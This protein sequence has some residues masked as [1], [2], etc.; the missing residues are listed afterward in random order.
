MVSDPQDWALVAASLHGNASDC[1]LFCHASL[2]SRRHEHR[3]AWHLADN[4]DAPMESVGISHDSGENGSAASAPES[5]SDPA[6]GRSCLHA[7]WWASLWCSLVF[8]G[9]VL[10]P[11]LVSAA[12][13]NVPSADTMPT[14]LPDMLPVTMAKGATESVSGI[15]SFWVL[16][17]LLSAA[18]YI[19]LTHR[20]K[21][22]ADHDPDPWSEPEFLDSVLLL[23][24]EQGAQLRLQALASADETALPAKGQG[25]NSVCVHFDRS[26]I[27]LL[28]EKPQSDTRA[29]SAPVAHGYIP[30]PVLDS[31]LA[32]LFP[33]GQRV[34][35]DFCVKTG[36]ENRTF[37]FDTM[38]LRHDSPANA[39]SIMSVPDIDAFSGLP[40]GTSVLELARP[41]RV[42]RFQRR[43]FERIR[44][45]RA[46]I[47]ALGVW[48][49]QPGPT[50]PRDP[51]NLAEFPAPSLAMLPQCKENIRIDNIS[52]NGLALRVRATTLAETRAQGA[53]WR[54]CIVFLSL[55]ENGHHTC[56]LWLA[57]VR[58]HATVSASRPSSA[59]LG[60]EIAGW[61]E[62]CNAQSPINWKPVASCG[63]TPPLL[64]W[65]IRRLPTMRRYR[66]IN[67]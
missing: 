43:T 14:A 32:P 28:P 58:R 55:R 18:A 53:Q 23:A 7:P 13:T 22:L 12:D 1:V 47:A 59:V 11:S 35:V 50:L 65:I 62:T 30:L 64:R 61:A 27:I 67:L 52:A 46:D 20:E 4:E 41:N 44:P 6:P 54:G 26:R 10:Y 3:K 8:A 31:L 45:H 51:A 66:R 19:Y 48:D 38:V 40:H 24:R 15:Y 42:A 34:R 37:Q 39:P 33:A 60:W 63:E 25:V 36:N 9:L 21:K 56:M 2:K 16:L 49:W 29:Q 17:I 5:V 57:C